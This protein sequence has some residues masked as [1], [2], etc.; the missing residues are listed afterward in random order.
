MPEKL[1]VIHPHFH[2]RRTGVT[3]HVEAVTGR[4]ME[5]VD[6][7]VIGPGLSTRLPHLGWREL[8]TLVRMRTAVWHA[9]RNNEL[10]LGLLLRA[11]GCKLKI[12]FTRHAAVP[13]GRYTRWLARRA[14]VRIALTQEVQR[15]LGLD[16]RVI[17]HGVDGRRFTEP[18]VRAQAWDELGVG[19]K[20]GV[21]V[22]GRIR[23]AKGQGDFGSAIA[24]LLERHVDWRAV[25]VG[26]VRPQDGSFAKKLSETAK[27]HFAG[28]Q[29]RIEP[30]YR[31]LSI[32]VQPSRSEGFSL[33]LLEAMA[34]GCCVVAA[35]LPHYPGIIEEGRTGF[36]YPPGDVEA[37]RK[38]LSSLME[39]PERVAQVGKQAAI[40]VR[41]RFELGVEVDALLRVYGA[42]G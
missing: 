42:E 14:D 39:Q 5:R 9:H 25:L 20:Y 32:L 37:L 13:A 11:L 29:E 19:G 1:L 16:S 8:W 31:G 40:A 15:S 30:W 6:A 28:Q 4:L 33:V 24:P 22:I 12:V 2:G 7:R 23:P 26:A 18:P 38:I 35:R 34:A 3:S 36:F 41:E 21:G 17:P 10:A 27:V